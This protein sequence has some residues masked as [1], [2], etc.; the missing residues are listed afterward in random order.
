MEDMEVT[1]M[2]N[3]PCEEVG[4]PVRS[5]VPSDPVVSVTPA[6]DIPTCRGKQSA[7]R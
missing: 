4:A 3:D 6:M 1:R 5:R 7:G 2:L